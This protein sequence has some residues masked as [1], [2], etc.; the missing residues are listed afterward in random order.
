MAEDKQSIRVDNKKR[1][2]KEKSP[3]KKMDVRMDLEDLF[4]RLV[5]NYG[6]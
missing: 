5:I 3:C 1:V 4:T 2:W 6:K